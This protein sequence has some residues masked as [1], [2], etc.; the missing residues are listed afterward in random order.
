MRGT[1]PLQLRAIA[2]ELDIPLSR[3]GAP[4]SIFSAMYG[5]GKF[6]SS[7]ASDHVPC[8]ECHVLGLL[9]SGAAVAALGLCSGLAGISGL[10]ALQGILQ[11][12]GWPL[13]SRVLVNELPARDRAKYWGVLSM[14][15]NIGSM[16]TPYG[17]VILSKQGLSWRMSLFCSG[18]S[19]F[20]VA[21]LVW[22]MLCRGT[23]RAGCDGG[24]GSLLKGSSGQKSKR[25][26]A[27]AKLA[28]RSSVTTVFT[29]PPLCALMLCNVLSFSASKCTKEWG[30]I[31]LR[32][33]GFATSDLE[34]ATLLFWAEVGGSCGALFSGIISSSMGGRHGRT[35]L[36]SAA[37]AVV[38]AS[39]LAWS[40]YSA[41]TDTSTP[42]SARRLS[43]ALTCT[44]QAMSLAG[45]NGVRTLVSL[46]AA[47]IAEPL[48]VV[49]MANGCLEIVGQVGSV[50]AGQ[51]LGAF[52]AYI[53][54]VA[55][56]DGNAGL[57]APAG[58]IAVLI[59]LAGEAWGLLALNVLLLPQEE[60][61]L[62]RQKAEKAD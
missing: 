6:F 15:G 49:G 25:C 23:V 47:E 61:R 21:T 20:L 26:P 41:S 44:L 10:W 57:D 52:A 48:G 14:A 24:S 2:M 11:A 50:L 42:V 32:S 38:S 58:W 8:T 17:T 59:V 1:L 35:C 27:E 43:F 36:L 16:L 51:P 39:T 34:C 46:H 53:S 40:S 30:V 37:L 60:R 4:T 12:L 54:A 7:L 56:G 31:Y 45:V 3:L 62:A 22:C 9:L 29:C 28:A 55:A 19:T 33:A 13:L 5:I 18:C